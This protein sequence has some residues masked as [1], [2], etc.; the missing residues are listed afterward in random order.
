M[1]GGVRIPVEGGPE[2]LAPADG[3]HFSLEE[4]QDAVGGYIELVAIPAVPRAVLIVDEDGLRKRLPAND[5][6][7]YLAQQRVVGPV[8]M[9]ARALLR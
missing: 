3:K 4:L 7:T 6:A 2:R 9:C 5:V 1:R 8:V